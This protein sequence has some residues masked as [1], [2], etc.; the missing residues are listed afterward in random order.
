MKKM[1]LGVALFGIVLVVTS[2]LQLRTF[3]IYSRAGYYDVL[4]VPLPENII[5]LRGIFSALLRIAG[6]AAG[7]GILLGKDLFRKTALF[8]A[9]ITIA[10]VYLKHPYY[11]VKKHAELSINY[12]AQKIGNFEIMSPAIIELVAKVSMAVLLAIDVFFSLAIIYYFT[13]PQIKRWFK[14]RG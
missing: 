7:M 12:V 5:F 2:F 1:P 13:L 11:A 3:L 8:V 10:T 14:D 9:G 4:F 6:L